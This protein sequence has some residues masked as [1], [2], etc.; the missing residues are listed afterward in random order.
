MP[1][2]R[3]SY[4]IETGPGRTSLPAG[5]SRPQWPRLMLTVSDLEDLGRMIGE[6]AGRASA[7]VDARVQEM[8][9]ASQMKPSENGA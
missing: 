6:D 1:N 8:V 7:W 2:S 4:A 9:S 5:R 3:L